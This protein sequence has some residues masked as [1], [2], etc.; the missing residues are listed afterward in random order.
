MV[1]VVSEAQIAVQRVR[2][3]WN[4]SWVV[5]YAGAQFYSNVVI[6][7]R[8]P[9]HQAILDRDVLA[10][11]GVSTWLV[12]QVRDALAEIVGVDVRAIFASPEITRLTISAPLACHVALS[13]PYELLA[14]RDPGLVVIRRLTGTQRPSPAVVPP[15]RR[16]VLASALVADDPYLPLHKEAEALVRLMEPTAFTVEE[17]FLSFSAEDLCDAGRG[18]AIVH[19]AGHG[20]HNGIRMSSRLMPNL[21]TVDAAQFV[22]AWRDNA[23]NLVV[24]NACESANDRDVAEMIGVANVSDIGGAEH[25]AGLVSGTASLSSMALAIAAALPTA[26]IALRV[27]VDDVDARRFA[28]SFYLRYLVDE[29]HLPSAFEAA[30][31]EAGF[32]DDLGV[33]VPRLFVNSAWTPIERDTSVEV[34]VRTSSVMTYGERRCMNIFYNVFAPLA[35]SDLTMTIVHVSGDN[36]TLRGLSVSAVERLMSIRWPATKMER[37]ERSPSE[38]AQVT[39]LRVVGAGPEKPVLMGIDVESLPDQIA[40]G[41]LFARRGTLSTHE[42]W[43]VHHATGSVPALVLG[44]LDADMEGLAKKLV[45][46][47]GERRLLLDPGLGWELAQAAIRSLPAGQRAELQRW[48]DHKWSIL[49]DLGPLAVDIA[50]VRCVQGPTHWMPRNTIEML[51][52]YIQDA[53]VTAAALVATLRALVDSGVAGI[54]PDEFYGGRREV[55]SVDLLT[56][57]RAWAA[58]SDSARI[59]HTR[60]FV[61]RAAEPALMDQGDVPVEWLHHLARLAVAGRS[62][63]LWLFADRLA[64]AGEENLAA[65]LRRRGE[66]VGMVALHLEKSSLA[67]AWSRFEDVSNTAFPEAGGYLDEIAQMPDANPNEVA[68]M[69][70]ALAASD[71]DPP[72]LLERAAALEEELLLEWT[73]ASDHDLHPLTLVRQAKAT[74]L[75][76]LGRRE[77]SA[78]VLAAHFEWA[79]TEVGPTDSVALAGALAVRRMLQVGMLAEGVRLADR[80]SQVAEALPSGMGKLTALSSGVLADVTSGRDTRAFVR[81]EALLALV[82]E[83][84]APRGEAMA[85]ILDVC[86]DA[87]ALSEQH[88]A[89]ALGLAALCEWFD[90]VPGLRFAP[91]ARSAQRLANLACDVDPDEVRSALSELVACLARPLTVLGRTVDGLADSLAAQIAAGALKLRRV[92]AGPADDLQVLQQLRLRSAARCP[93]ARLL[94]RSFCSDGSDLAPP[95]DSLTIDDLLLQQVGLPTL[96]NIFDDYLPELTVAGL[97]LVAQSYRGVP[98]ARVVWFGLLLG[99]LMQEETSGLVKVLVSLGAG[100]DWDTTLKY[101]LTLSEVELI[102]ACVAV[103]ACLNASMSTED[104]GAGRLVEMSRTGWLQ[105]VQQQASLDLAAA[106]AV[107]TAMLAVLGAGAAREVFRDNQDVQGQ[108]FPSDAWLIALVSESH[109]KAA[110][111]L[112][113]L[114]WNDLADDALRHVRRVARSADLALAVRVQGALLDRAL[115]G[116][117]RLIAIHELEHTL[118]CARVV[119]PHLPE[120]CVIWSKV[121]EAAFLLSQLEVVV[122]ASRQL[123]EVPPDAVQPMVFLGAWFNLFQVLTVLG[124]HDEALEPLRKLGVVFGLSAA[125][126][127][128]A[129]G[130]KWWMPEEEA[131]DAI[132]ET[133]LAIAD[134]VPQNRDRASASA[135]ASASGPIDRLLSQLPDTPRW[136]DLRAVLEAAR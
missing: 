83:W 135:S 82:G 126:G 87:T 26:V 84:G 27:P 112:A 46:I 124:R 121:S 78:A 12:Q 88:G 127:T 35:E 53:G 132:C 3:P 79:I 57:Y 93:L 11:T 94:L 102:N 111:A 30:V 16:I 29:L 91:N 58:C 92:P 44:V 101:L 19:I 125:C 85:L 7:P 28:E 50:A 131:A 54:G 14:P 9:T 48:S 6:D 40:V 56:A 18:A 98:G 104:E 59:A 45:A 96:R 39:T 119:D 32:T 41:E 20:S 2:G 97:P 31:R 47:A 60:A 77:E 122:E 5:Q 128:A 8:N 64:E 13:L 100:Q 108:E 115:A 36:E 22:R 49:R 68:A 106:K 55:T 43:L 33:P 42:L 129:D 52:H 133:L 69:R 51:G 113:S 116:D 74:A 25:L 107:V 62:D 65:D 67:K 123:G 118:Q 75:L 130:A 37:T 38:N 80:L 90:D 63:A 15:A 89:R 110:L 70:L 10:G 114:D 109:V 136:S 99:D 120:Y 103:E 24:L 4:W 1:F 73:S 23:P 66:D 105:V 72:A 76:A 134:A 61:H 117:E 34:G 17:M 86:R 95:L 21:N 81:S 71:E